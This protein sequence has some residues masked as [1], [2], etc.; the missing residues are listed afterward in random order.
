MF[1]IYGFFSFFSLISISNFD[2]SFA[3]SGTWKFCKSKCL[4]GY[5]RFGTGNLGHICDF[6]WAIW[7][8]LLETRITG[9]HSTYS[10]KKKS[11]RIWKNIENCK[12][13]S[14][15]PDARFFCRV[16]RWPRLNANNS[17]VIKKTKNLQ[18]FTTAPSTWTKNF[19]KK[20]FFSYGNHNA[21]KRRLFESRKCI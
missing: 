4:R 6:F 7:N 13:C 5:I 1:F 20:T 2:F 16:W 12:S 11:G 10:Y 8:N 14:S 17:T 21:K 3:Y 9:I 15:C 19:E 18:L